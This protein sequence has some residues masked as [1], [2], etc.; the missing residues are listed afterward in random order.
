M[1][2]LVFLVSFALLGLFATAS[3]Q[4]VRG[5]RL[6]SSPYSS[7][8]PAFANLAAWN[9]TAQGMEAG[10]GPG[11]GWAALNFM[12]LNQDRAPVP[13]IPLLRQLNPMP[14]GLG[15]TAAD[16]EWIQSAMLNLRTMGNSSSAPATSGKDVKKLMDI[17]EHARARAI[18]E[19]LENATSLMNGKIRIP[20]EPVEHRR[21]LRARIAQ[22]SRLSERFMGYEL[23]D[24]G[25][26]ELSVEV[27]DKIGALQ[28]VWNER[29]GGPLK[30]EG[31]A[32]LTPGT[33][34]ERKGLRLK[35][36]GKSR[37]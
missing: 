20:S 8:A 36:S 37:R 23:Y 15:Y 26:P 5:A 10:V 7:W 13:L 14:G 3:A 19:A 1:R 4:P 25:L 35:V 2:K 28:E 11:T 32:V 30:L 27:G 9:H 21:R 17:L 33:S 22:L 29:Y 16:R 6:P 24:G 31:V 12:P 18:P 34:F